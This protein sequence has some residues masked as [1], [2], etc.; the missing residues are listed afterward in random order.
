M[1]DYLRTANNEL[2]AFIIPG[3]Y[4]G[5]GVNV[6]TGDPRNPWTF[7]GPTQLGAFNQNGQAYRWQTF[8][9]NGPKPMINLG[10]I[11]GD[12][13]VRNQTKAPTNSLQNSEFGVRYSSLLPIGN[14]L[15]AS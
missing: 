6:T 15:Q 7:P 11:F 3:Y 9:D 2:E 1:A 10:G 14:G 4:Q 5:N 12:F 8:L 13:A